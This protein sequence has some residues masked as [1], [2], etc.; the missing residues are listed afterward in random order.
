[1][2]TRQAFLAGV[3]LVGLALLYAAVLYPWLPAKIPCHWNIRGEVDGW[4]DKFWGVLMTPGTMLLM[5]AMMLGL[6]AISPRSFRIESFLGT[7]NYAMFIIIGLMGYIHFIMLQAALHPQ[8]DMGR[9][10]LGGMFLFFALIGNVLGK[11]R[12]NFWMGV[13][14]PWTLASDSVWIATHRLAGRL[15]VGAGLL[16]MVLALLGVSPVF[17]FTLFLIAALYPALYSFILYRKQNGRSA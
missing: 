15:M 17:C 14:T 1:M 5:L 6:P 16:G 13:R 4:I 11:V 3:G 12:R 2:K 10:L 7:W 8:I 9:L